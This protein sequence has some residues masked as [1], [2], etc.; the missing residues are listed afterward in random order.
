MM[1]VEGIVVERTSKLMVKP[2]I[3][4]YYRMQKWKKVTYSILKKKMF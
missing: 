1:E 4:V 2:R 3:N